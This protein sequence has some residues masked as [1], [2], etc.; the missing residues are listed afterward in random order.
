MNFD[1]KTIGV[2]GL[3]LVGQSTIRFVQKYYP[4]STLIAMDKRALTQQEQESLAK[5]RIAFFHQTTDLD[6][7]FTAADYIIP[8]PGINLSL[9]PHYH[10]KYISEVD[11]FYHHWHKPSIAITGT[12]GKTTV[13]TTLAHLMRS[14]GLRVA[15]GGNI[16]T[17]GM[18]CLLDLLTHQDQVDYAVLELSSFQLEQSTNASPQ[19]AV[20]SNIYPNHLDYHGTFDAYVKAKLRCL[21]PSTTHAILPYALLSAAQ[22][23]NNNITY[24]GISLTQPENESAHQDHIY[25]L[26]TVKNIIK[27]TDD[28]YAI[29]APAHDVPSLGYAINW[30]TIV[31][32]LH[33][34]GLEAANLNE[35]TLQSTLPEHR[36]TRVATINN[37]HFYNDSKATIPQATFAAI[38]KIQTTNIIL[39]W[40]GVSKGVDRLIYLKDFK[41]RIKHL[42]CFG[43]EA[44]LL[45]QQ[46][47]HEGLSCTMTTTIEE[48][49][50]A[51][52]TIAQ[53]G[54]HI[55]FS[56]A[57]A[58]FDLFS[59][60]QERGNKFVS[61]VKE[62]QHNKT[63]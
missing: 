11:L 38:E 22:Q 56:P 41:G 55:L 59:N 57:G 12:V 13:T 2:W 43:K 52:V 44:P 9:Y 49:F 17:T 61:L 29:V 58:S 7:F 6:S 31:A 32:T 50:T 62:Y 24:H 16:G 21:R 28:N 18:S 23:I 60:Y 46:A 19:I 8:S 14:Y 48:A 20:I 10:G 5:N 54:D 45:A 4:T 40:G 26:D 51:A 33:A 1:D 35:R 3:G 53:P 37:I 30:L 63:N 47:L 39:M 27:Q 25:Y 42:I 36:L 15:V 34:L